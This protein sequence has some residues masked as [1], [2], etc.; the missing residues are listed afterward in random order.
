MTVYDAK[1]QIQLRLVTEQKVALFERQ[2]GTEY[3]LLAYHAALP[4]VLTP[5]LVHY[6]RTE[7]L[8]DTVPWEAEADLLLSDLCS[9]VGYELYA[10]DSDM[11]AYLLERMQQDGEVPRERMQ[12]VAQLLISYVTYLQKINPEQRMRELQAQ[13]WAAMAYLGDE[14]CRQMV[15]ELTAQFEA[16]GEQGDSNAVKAEFVRLA[17]IT[18]ELA[19]QLQQYPEL[20]EFAKQVNR[21]IR[22]PQ[23][24]TAEDL[25]RSFTVGDR[26]LKL[27]DRN[28]RFPSLLLLN[29]TTAQLVESSDTVAPNLNWLPPLQTEEYTVAEIAFDSETLNQASI[30]LEQF[31]FKVGYLVN[32]GNGWVVQ[33]SDGQAYRYLERISGD[34]EIEMVA[35]SGG[36]FMMG[37]P[38]EELDRY[39]FESP[40]HLVTVRDFYMGRYPVTQAQWRAVAAMPQ[41]ERELELDPSNFKGDNRPVEQVSWED[42]IEFC[43]RLSAYTNRLYRLPTEAEWEYACRAGTTTP[44]HF[45]ENISTEL[46]NYNGIA[47]ADGNA[48]E[49]RRITTP[50]DHFDIAN[51]W[52]LCDMHGNV[53]EWCQDHWHDNYEGA[54]EDG[55]SW[56]SD[57]SENIKYVIRGGSWDYYPRGCRSACRYNSYPDVRGN[58][59]GFRVSCSAPATL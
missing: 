53:L 8:G 37:S 7:F 33:K 16:N 11:R 54:P 41:V 30:E 50:V 19:V 52:G 58:Y 59:L 38:V 1:E 13:R 34:I 35:I 51:A 20:V 40:Q 6:L 47:Y 15:E 2:F 10:M 49:S 28:D 39:V 31:A 21:A 56:M 25:D 48:G 14:S 29:F 32:L 55:S 26:V 5:E 57:D 23:L 24:L 3:R 36:E 18:Q 12:Q 44:F 45:G 27:P 22:Q 17:R 43:A 4:L 46:A 42:A 9:Q